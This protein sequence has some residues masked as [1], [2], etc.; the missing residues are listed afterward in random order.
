[1]ILTTVTS[2][3]SR[4]SS[5]NTVPIALSTEQNEGYLSSFVTQQTGCGNLENPW[6]LRVS[7]GQ[8]INITLIDFTSA[9]S[10]YQSKNDH[11]CNVY[12]TIKDGNGAVTHTVCGGTGR[13]VTPVFMS[14]T[15]NVEIKITSKSN[16]MKNEGHFLLKYTGV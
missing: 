10:E 3:V 15:N 8:R 11:L 1:M 12:A 16:Q 9:N 7:H 2:P 6:L 14:V 5:S 4:C 13:K